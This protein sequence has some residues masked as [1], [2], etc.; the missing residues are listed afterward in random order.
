M[1]QHY[2]HLAFNQQ[3]SIQNQLRE[4]LINAILN[5]VFP[6]TEALPSCRNLSDQLGISRNTVALVYES[7]LDKGYIISKPRSGYYLHPDYHT[8]QEN[9]HQNRSANPASETTPN[10][11]PP[12][13][14]KKLHLNQVSITAS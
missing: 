7:I 8:D 2:F 6:D 4:S 10:I 3:D 14:S 12:Q 1:I 13:W 11:T 5:G 9:T